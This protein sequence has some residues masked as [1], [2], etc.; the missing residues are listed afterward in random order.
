MA[1]REYDLAIVG[2]GPGGY[3]AAIRASQLGLRTALI[4]KYSKAGGTC[5]NVGCIP[6]KALLHSSYLYEQTSKV[7][8]SHGI[9]TGSKTSKPSFDLAK[10]QERKDSVVSSLTS[11]IAFLLQKNKITYIEGEAQLLPASDGTSTLEVANGNDRQSVSAKH[12]VLALGSEPTL[13]P[14]SIAKVD[15]RRIL[16]STGALSLAAVP[17]HL[18]IVGAGVIGLELGSVWSRLGSDVTVIDTLDHIGG[19]DAD[20]AQEFQKILQTQG[21][22][23]KL[24]TS[25]VSLKDDKSGV[26]I[27]TSSRAAANTSANESAN[28]SNANES[29]ANETWSASHVLL[30]IGRKAA[31]SSSLAAA[32]VA[33]DER[34]FIVVDEDFRTSATGVYAI[35]DCIGGA[36]LAHK[37]EDEGVALVESLAG[38]RSHVDYATI[39]GVIYTHPEVAVVGLSEREAKSRGLPYKLGKFPFRANARSRTTGSDAGLVK[40][41][42][43]PNDGRLLGAQILGDEAGTLIQELVAI[44]AYRGTAED[45][46]HICHPHPTLNEALREAALATMGRAIHI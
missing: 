3:V 37:A 20:L 11:G 46:A 18:A 24:K 39:A 29:N 30:A 16:T 2:A 22:S 41:L 8:A 9:N 27:T 31:T 7:L 25:L 13:L 43:A 32:G 26:S 36:M 15:E 5:L 28:E 33:C 44:M 38:N 19:L 4:N 6:S 42:V 34:G 14:S 45:I 1:S 17:S 23:F 10:M 21:F 40:L 35:G 12:I